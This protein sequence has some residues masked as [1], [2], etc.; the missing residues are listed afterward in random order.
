MSGFF[1]T[2]EGPDG[3]GKTT[4]IKRLAESLRHLGY[5]VVLTREPGGTPISDQIR[6]LLLNPDYKEMCAQAEILLYAASRAQ[7]VQQVIRP[8]IAKGKIVLCDRFVEASIAYQ[9]Y[10]NEYDMETVVRTNDV[11]T[12]GLK[13]DRTYML[14]IQPEDALGRMKRRQLETGV[15]ADRMEQKG[16]AF[17]QRVFEGFV[18]IANS[19]PERIRI[20]DA[21][22]TIE[23][24]AETILMDCQVFLSNDKI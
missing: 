9:A 19:D 24:I 1:I 16:E 17:H 4:Q 21:K 20:I 2:F 5:D 8:S 12:G 13:P 11:A 22:G 15:Q 10:G 6:T 18:H 23:Q 7:H 14:M 3:T